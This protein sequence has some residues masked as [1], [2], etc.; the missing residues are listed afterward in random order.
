VIESLRIEGLALVERLELAFGPGLN[1]LTGETGAGKSVVLGALGLLAGGRA[2]P[3][4]VREAA[5]EAV[6]EAVFRTTGLPE[7]EAALAERGLEAE[8]GALIVRRAIARGGRARAWIGARLVPVSTLAELFA[9]RIEI[10]S[11]HES[12]GLLQ[13]A[14]QSRVLDAHGGLL[15]LRDEVAQ[16]VRALA[17]DADEIARLRAEADERERRRDFLAFQVR[18]ID[19]ARLEPGE[20]AALE[21]EHRRLVHAGRLREEAEQAA[22]F[23]AGDPLAPDA[24]GADDLLSR[25]ARLVAGLAE[26]DPALAEGAARLEAARGEL[27]DAARDLERYAAGV[28]VDPARLAEVEERLRLLDRLRRKYGADEAAVLA[29]RE[30]AAAEL[31]ALG[32]SDERL[33]KLE[34]E[35]SAETARVAGRAAELSRRRV[36]A[37]AALASAVQAE[38]A[39]LALPD[40]RFEVALAPVAPLPGAPCGAAGA[41]AAEFL[42]SANPGEPAQPLRRVASGGELSRVFLALKNVLRRAGAGMV[43]VFDEVDAGV[44]GRVAE[45]VGS[46]LAA[47]AA[48]HQVLCITHLPQIAAQADAHFRVV[49]ESAGGRTVTRVEPLDA[50]GRVAEI[51]RMAGG[52]TVS[53]ATR[54]HARAL[55]RNARREPPRGGPTRRGGRKGR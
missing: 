15:A 55:L 44:G 7:L 29:F 6:V 5:E 28:E 54:D 36:A 11:Q 18:E 49:K 51:A 16:G 9:G 38:L 1:V 42:L 12:Q 31:A 35:R 53:D 50:D 3:A 13:P 30:A 17:A 52:E 39:Q 33:R 22:A 10:S 47:L 27:R 43:L 40:A 20:G 34:G 19:E 24:P 26:L 32:G 46:V 48:E 23:L 21:A 41:E 4:Q 14:L 25:A 37:A 45:R 2:Q 8:D